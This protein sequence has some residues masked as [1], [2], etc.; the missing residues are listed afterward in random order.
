MNKRVLV[1]V[2]ILVVLIAGAGTALALSRSGPTPD[3]APSPTAEAQNTVEPVPSEEPTVAAGPGVYVDYSESAIA[4]AEGRILL[5]FHAT[6]CSQCR[7]I[8]SDIVDQGVPDGVT[9]IKVDYDAYQP[10][11]QDYGVTQQTTFIEV[12]SSGEALQSHVAYD[13][14]HL[15]AVVAA[16]L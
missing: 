9:I 16:M 6:W 1:V 5:F 10:V 7:S 15:D 2:A 4:D 12:T 8:E 14:P 11:R 13:D 3:A